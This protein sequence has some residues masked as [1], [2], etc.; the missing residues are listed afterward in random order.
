MWICRRCLATWPLALGLIVAGV[1]LRWPLATPWELALWLV[2]VT[3][4][5]I[6]VH[7]RW[8]PYSA[9]RTWLFGAMLGIGL[10]RTFHRYVLQ[11]TDLVAWIALSSVGLVCGLAAV[12]HFTLKKRELK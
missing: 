9:S 2:P 12:Y 10:G 1:G 8:A 6:A 7:L 11:P 3:V 5:Y 4:E